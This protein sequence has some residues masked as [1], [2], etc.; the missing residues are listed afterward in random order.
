MPN[1]FIQ[2]VF[3]DQYGS[4]NPLDNQPQIEKKEKK[5]VDFHVYCLITVSYMVSFKKKAT[6]QAERT[7]NLLS[8]VG[9]S[10]VQAERYALRSFI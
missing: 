9:R 6:V 5:T 4:T 7:D 8:L 1:R 10:T 2:G 3:T